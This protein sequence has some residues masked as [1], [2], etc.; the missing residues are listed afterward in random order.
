MNRLSTSFKNID[1]RT[2]EG[3]ERDLQD[4]RRTGRVD[5]DLEEEE[6]TLEDLAAMR[7]YLLRV[8]NRKGGGPR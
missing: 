2:M 3:L 5:R 1:R 8:K 4:H 6:E 7:E